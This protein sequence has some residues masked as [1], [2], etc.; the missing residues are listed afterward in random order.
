MF[1]PLFGHTSEKTNSADLRLRFAGAEKK[2]G[3]FGTHHVPKGK[4]ERSIA[5]FLWIP[6]AGGSTELRWRWE[7]E[8][9]SGGGP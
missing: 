9:E 2:L 7:V 8:S 4:N 5:A 3:L 6:R 1:L